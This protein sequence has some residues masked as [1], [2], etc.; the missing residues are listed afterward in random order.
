MKFF[1]SAP[2][3]LN[4]DNE[5]DCSLSSC[6]TIDEKPTKA[7]DDGDDFD[8]ETEGKENRDEENES[9]CTTNN[10]PSEDSEDDSSVQA[11]RN[12]NRF[13]DGSIVEN[14]N[15]HDESISNTDLN[16]VV[17]LT[18]SPPR[19][20]SSSAGS[21]TATS[22]ASQ[23]SPIDDKE[24]IKRYRR[25]AKR[26]KRKAQQLASTHSEMQQNNREL[27]L[28]HK[29]LKSEVAELEQEVSEFE[30]KSKEQ[31]LDLSHYKLKVIR[32][33]DQNSNLADQLRSSEEREKQMRSEMASMQN[34]HKKEVEAKSNKSMVEHGIMIRRS[35]QIEEE[36]MELRERVRDLEQLS[37]KNSASG[38]QSRRNDEVTVPTKKRKHMGN[39]AKSL[40]QMD[41]AD[42]PS[43]SNDRE[44]ESFLEQSSASLN[45][46]S[47]SKESR[48]RQSSC[49]KTSISSVKYS[50]LALRVATA[51]NK[52]IAMKSA[53]RTSDLLEAKNKTYEIPIEKENGK[54]PMNKI[55][56]AGN[57]LNNHR[58]G[59]VSMH[60]CKGL[61]S[62]QSFLQSM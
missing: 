17:D 62:R 4:S 9:K 61:T 8:A 28:K 30:S 6:S 13:G 18:M 35:K 60:R 57:Q 3:G 7:E 21:R 33:E 51:A 47:A 58:T 11:N 44:C 25:I 10:G 49:E 16:F 15:G 5:D 50:D 22:Q 32:L 45:P 48:K 46:S 19:K 2:E 55:R 53:R 26:Y 24:C 31:E 14:M 56:P 38:K 52:K 54:V 43:F 34:R 36:N 12:P 1:L 29:D 40:R 59:A 27:L 41:K 42:H 20:H 37:Q 39:L 23:R